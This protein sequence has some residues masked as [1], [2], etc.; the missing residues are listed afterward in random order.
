MSNDHTVD[1]ATLK[2]ICDAIDNILEHS[3]DA[4]HESIAD[5]AESKFLETEIIRRICASCNCSE[6]DAKSVIDQLVKRKFF[7]RKD[8]WIWDA[9]QPLWIG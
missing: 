9:R 7:G 2:Q 8:G 6:L 3:F 1:E 5:D 4:H